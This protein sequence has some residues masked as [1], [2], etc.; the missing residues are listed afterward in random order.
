MADPSWTRSAARLPDA[1]GAY[2]L[3]VVLD[4]SVELPRRFGGARLGKGCYCYVGSAWGAGGIRGRCA[5]HLRAPVTRHWHVD[6]LLAGAADR[7][8]RAFPGR[9][10]CAV[11]RDLLGI[12]GASVAVPGFGNTDCR[13]CPSHLLTLDRDALAVLPDRLARGGTNPPRAAGEFAWRS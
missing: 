8:I 2:A 6:W 7:R 12:G 4:R 11:V 5:R 3:L 9:S 1:G 10:E 13:R